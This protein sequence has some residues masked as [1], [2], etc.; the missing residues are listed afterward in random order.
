MVIA[1]VIVMLKALV[2]ALLNGNGNSNVEGN[3]TGNVYG[4][5]DGNSSVNGDIFMLRI[6][7][8]N[9]FKAALPIQFSSKSLKVLKRCIALSDPYIIFLN[10]ELLQ[11]FQT[12]VLSVC[13]FIC[14]YFDVGRCR[15]R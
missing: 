6:F 11:G 9:T 10:T 13:V 7:H 8:V 14:I 3:S 4:D 5:D 1:I 2:M 12:S 15:F